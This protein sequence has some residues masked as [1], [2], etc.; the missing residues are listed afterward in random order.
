ML[1]T[2][3]PVQVDYAEVL[4]LQ[5]CE[6]LKVTTGEQT[7]PTMSQEKNMSVDALGLIELASNSKE[8]TCMH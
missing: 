4:C 2:P 7:V 6:Q 1:S 3:A 8:D 5:L